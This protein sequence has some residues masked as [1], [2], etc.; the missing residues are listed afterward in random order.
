MLATAVATAVAAA[1][2]TAAGT[3]A[4]TAT[5]TAPA[6][7]AFRPCSLRAA[8]GAFGS[9]LLQPREIEEIAHEVKNKYP[10]T[11][12]LEMTDLC[13]SEIAQEIVARR[14][15]ARGKVHQLERRRP[16]NCTRH[17]EEAVPPHKNAPPCRL[18]RDASKPP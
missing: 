14:A 2:G 15:W 18:P 1:A 4:A 16:E 12:K 9:L 6:A 5:A 10:L 11:R 17:D 7:L 3:A 13:F 8:W